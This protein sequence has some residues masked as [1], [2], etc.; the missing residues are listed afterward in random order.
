MPMSFIKNTAFYALVVVIV[1]C[2]VSRFTT[3]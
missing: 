3:R 2:A 1:V